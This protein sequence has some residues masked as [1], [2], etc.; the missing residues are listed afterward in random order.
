MR[1]ASTVKRH[2][3]Q[4][5]RHSRHH[6]PEQQYTE[7]TLRADSVTTKNFVAPPLDGSNAKGYMVD[8][9]DYSADA[10]GYMMD[11]KGYGVDA[12]LRW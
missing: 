9:K 10:K 2:T 4:P 8:V 5:N 6:T 1:T 12:T 11:V 7:C 3:A